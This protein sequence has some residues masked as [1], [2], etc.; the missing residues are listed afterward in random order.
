VRYG[1][2][3]DIHANV[4]AFVVAYEKLKAV[5]VDQTIFLGDL[6]GYGPA[7]A[8]CVD[9]F[10]GLPETLPISGNHDRQVLGERDPYMRRT[11]ARALEWTRNQLSPKQLRTL[12]SFPQGRTVEDTFIVVHGSLVSRDAYIRSMN[13]VKVNRK[14][15]VE[16]FPGS[17]VCFFGHTHVPLLAGTKDTVTDL[18]E[19]KAFQL[20]P[21]DVYLVN[22]GSVGQ[23]R[24]GCPLS[25]FG[26][27]DSDNWTMTFFREPY[28][29]AGTCEAIREA[30]LPEK[31]ARRLEAGT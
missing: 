20:D 21:D 23:P 29:V 26:V 4:R 9:L 5:G 22:P 1:L 6:V 11:A 3:A 16:D 27:F 12:Q 10:A 18:K 7:P 2:I 25:A 15:M 8:A 31:F 14:S 13:D 24:D 30:G 17:R 28:D 19:T